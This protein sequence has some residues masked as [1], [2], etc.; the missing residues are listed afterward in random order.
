MSKEKENANDMLNQLREKG[1]KFD[2]GLT[3]A[4]IH[5]IE[6]IYDIR[7]PGSLRRFYSLGVPRVCSLWLPVPED[8]KDVSFG[9]PKWGDFSEANIAKIKKGIIM[10]KPYCH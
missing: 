10:L 5:K 2:E 7:F 8:F 9:F 1:V 4:E 6:G 3:E